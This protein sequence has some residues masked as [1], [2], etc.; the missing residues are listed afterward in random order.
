MISAILY[1]EGERYTGFRASGHSGYAEA[2][3]DI[4]CAAVSILSCTCV[5]S[6]ESLLGVTP[7]INEYADGLLDFELPEVPAE[8]EDGVQ[9]LMGSLKQGLGDLQEGYP[10]YIRLDIK[11]RRKE[12]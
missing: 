10:Q 5:N 2:G 4:V 11:G 7:R 9:L 6:L 3:S 1:R 8:K 12:R